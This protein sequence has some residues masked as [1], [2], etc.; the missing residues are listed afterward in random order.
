MNGCEDKIARKMRFRARQAIESD[1][2]TCQQN[3]VSEEEA[4]EG[5]GTRNHTFTFNFLRSAF[6]GGED[7]TA[8]FCIGVPLLNRC[9][10]SFDFT[11]A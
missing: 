3:S 6:F 1:C 2:T 9:F 8:F 11:M 7:S 4:G 5:I 10:S